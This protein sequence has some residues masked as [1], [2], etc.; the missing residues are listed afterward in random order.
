[1]VRKYIELAD[2]NCAVNK[3]SLNNYIY[4]VAGNLYFKLGNYK[5]ALSLFK[6][7]FGFAGK[8][9][10][11]EKDCRNIEEIVLLFETHSDLA[12]TYGKLEDLVGNFY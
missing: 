10:A 8:S 11:D 3:I 6:K 2:R 7:R 4:G 5:E 9:V 12:K 1:M